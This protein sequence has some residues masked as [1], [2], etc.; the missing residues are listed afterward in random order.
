MQNLCI[1]VR[2]F[3]YLCTEKVAFGD[4]LMLSKTGFCF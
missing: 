3:Y 2:D 1:V 4:F